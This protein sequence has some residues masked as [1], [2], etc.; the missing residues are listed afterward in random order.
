M[1]LTSRRKQGLQYEDNGGNNNA[2]QLLFNC[3]PAQQPN[4]QIKIRTNPQNV[5]QTYIQIFIIFNST[6]T[7][8]YIYIYIHTH[9][10]TLHA[11]R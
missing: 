5:T 9:T 2:V 3:L 7:Y 6:Y 8:I 1:P 11:H 10:H 4:N